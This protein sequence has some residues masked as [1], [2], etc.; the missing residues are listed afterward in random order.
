[1]TIVHVRYHYE[2]DAWWAESDDLPGWTA[3]GATF[4]EVR[5]MA[6]T[7]VVEFA[8]AEAAVEEEGVPISSATTFAGLNEAT[9]AI[10]HV[11]GGGAT[12]SITQNIVPIPRVR[13]RVQVRNAAAIPDERLAKH[14]EKQACT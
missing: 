4:E 13:L 5:K 6:R 3:V 10:V 12:L 2:G 14:I 7:G 11:I 9:G 1:M 8:G